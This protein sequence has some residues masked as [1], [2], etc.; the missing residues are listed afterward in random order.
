[1]TI[2]APSTVV[3]AL[4]IRHHRL[5]ALDRF[6]ARIGADG[7]CEPGLPATLIGCWKSVPAKIENA[8]ARDR[9]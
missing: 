6:A 7:R 8:A 5:R 4:M 1:V 3:K 2:I 9:K